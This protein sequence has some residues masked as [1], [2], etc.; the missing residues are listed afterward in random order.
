MPGR[1]FPIQTAPDLTSAGTKPYRYGFNGKE[2]DFEIKNSAGSSYDY[3]A[4]MYDPRLGRWLAVDP[5]AKKYPEESPYDY[6][7]N[8]PNYY[9]DPD[10][11]EVEPAVGGGTV[12]SN[13]LL[14]VLVHAAAKV[15]FDALPGYKGEVSFSLPFIKMGRADLVFKDANGKGAIWEIKPITYRAPTKNSEAQVQVARY[16][17]LA[18]MADPN[19]KFAI[20]SSEGAPVPIEGTVKLQITDGAVMYDV[21]LFIPKTEGNKGLIY[22]TLTNPRL[23]PEAE[24]VKEIVKPYAVA[25]AVAAV[26]AAAIATA[27]ETGGGS[28]VAG[29]VIIGT[30]L[31]PTTS[32]TPPGTPPA[33]C[34][35]E[36]Y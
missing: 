3:G 36:C 19:T 23:T 7:L 27:P 10:G 4:R 14:G 17:A 12:T 33:S 30:M 1:T 34:K 21:N 20:G 13:A 24:L 8:N 15:Y 5:M 11:N 29:S 35:D 16:R 22:Y 2:S 9:K 31:S 25:A 26:G 32:A 18:Q 28:V 6:C